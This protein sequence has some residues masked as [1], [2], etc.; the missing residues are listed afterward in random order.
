MHDIYKLKEMLCEE[1]EEYGRK[2]EMTPGT[3]EV[4]DKLAHA[5]K[6]LDKI[7]ETADEEYSG[8]DM[9]YRNG[10]EIWIGGLGDK[11]Q[12]DR[13]LGHEYPDLFLFILIGYAVIKLGDGLDILVFD[14]LVYGL[15]GHIAPQIQSSC[16]C[17][18][19]Q[20]DDW[21]CYPYSTLLFLLIKIAHESSTQL[22]PKCSLKYS[23]ISRLFL[24]IISSARLSVSSMPQSLSLS[25]TA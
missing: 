24:S 17:N 9:S 8:D 11:E 16:H 23:F 25:Y 18:G 7:I 12:V 15:P 1:L 2:G 10:S 4:V 13:I 5:V 21:Q 14:G 6:N 20:E 3:L 19:G 22:S